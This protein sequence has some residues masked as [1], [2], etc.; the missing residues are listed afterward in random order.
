MVHTLHLGPNWVPVSLLWDACIF[1]ILILGR[2]GLGRKNGIKTLRIE[3]Q[4]DHAMTTYFGTEGRRVARH[5]GL[6]VAIKTL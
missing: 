3:V 4:D 6:K 2:W 1:T 5:L